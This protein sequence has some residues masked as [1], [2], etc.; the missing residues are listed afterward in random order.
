MWN[1]ERKQ[2]IDAEDAE[3]WLIGRNV[4]LGSG[5]APV[6]AVRSV[7]MADYGFSPLQQTICWYWFRARINLAD[8]GHANC[9]LCKA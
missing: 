5:Y 4:M 1:K 7:A 6:V 2:R 8:S 9:H 3:R